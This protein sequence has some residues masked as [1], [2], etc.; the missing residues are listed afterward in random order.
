MALLGFN[1]IA[2]VTINAFHTLY[3]FWMHTKAIYKMPR[4]FEYIFNTPSHH[5]VHHG[6]N[7]KYIDKNHGGTLII[8]DRLFGSFQTEEEEVIYGVTK[9][10]A[11]WN[12]V[13]ANF[14]W[15]ADMWRDLKMEMNWSD[16]F[17]LL[18]NKPGWLPAHLGGYRAP[19][20]VRV[21]QVSLYDTA[22]PLGL[23]YYILFQYL[24]VLGVTSGFYLTWIFFPDFS[25]C[26]LLLR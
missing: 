8:F 26:S 19:Q 7:P 3:Q 24:I 11:S 25:N 6:R 22:I 15:Y 4:W 23:N 12:P 21:G 14:D 13:W 20:E 18:V 10:L 5:R 2:F 1:S 17:R 16:R 9:P